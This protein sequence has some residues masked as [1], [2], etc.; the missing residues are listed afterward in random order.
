[1][2]HVFVINPA[3][4]SKNHYDDVCNEIDKFLRKEEYVVY[5]TKGIGD[6]ISFVK[7]YI[8]THKNDTIRFYACGGDGT[9]NEV[10]NG[11]V[12]Y[13]NVEVTNYPIG[14]AND[15]LK[16]F[17]DKDFSNLDNLI[18]GTAV[19]IDLLKINDRYVV[20]IFNVGF[21]AKVV[22]LQR[23][24]KKFPLLGGSLSYK[25]G[26]FLSLFGK[27]AHKAQITVD[28]ELVFD[29]QMVLCAVANS[30]CYGGGYYCA[31]LAKIDDNILDV[32][33]VS[34]LS[35]MKFA[36]IVKVY[37]NGKHLEDERTKP[38]VTYK[39]GTKVKIDLEKPLFYSIDGELGKSKNIV[40]EVIPKVCRFVIPN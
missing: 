28:D 3:S 14:S 8:E 29:G 38:Y 10:V 36:K 9:L 4:G 25:L 40:L 7:E 16:Y 32:C 23:K 11:A 6:A 24:I 33:F 19:D 5:K 17:K 1:M 31:P 39:Q 12:G 30:I 26:V 27:L 13:Q 18:K 21:D 20:N 34:K 2:K 35:V 37:K 22:D 15:F